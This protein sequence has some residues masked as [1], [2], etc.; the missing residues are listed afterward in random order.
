MPF[1]KYAS[2]PDDPNFREAL[3][4]WARKFTRS[5]AVARRVT[6][7]TIDVL[8]DNPSLLDGRDINEAI[9]ML[10]RRH[11]FDEIEWSS[12][13]GHQGDGAMSEK[14]PMW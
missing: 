5:E 14:Q 1:R 12:E 13:Q 9:F 3:M 11:A 10:L 6:R 7:R 8:C 4:V 2:I